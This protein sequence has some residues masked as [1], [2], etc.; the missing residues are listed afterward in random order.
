[1]VAV[2]RV[3]AIEADLSIH[4]ERHLGSKIAEPVT[5]K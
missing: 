3:V 5:A 2:F 4:L 1:M